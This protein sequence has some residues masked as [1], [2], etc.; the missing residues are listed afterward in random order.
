MNRE[1]A[2]WPG[3]GPRSASSPPDW[4]APAVPQ[5]GL[6]HDDLPAVAFHSQKGKFLCVVCIEAKMGMTVRDP[7]EGS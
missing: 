7:A 6:P 3:G 2:S 4:K 1:S 5:E